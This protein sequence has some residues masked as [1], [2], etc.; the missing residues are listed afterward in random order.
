[1]EHHHENKSFKQ[2]FLS[3]LWGVLDL[4]KPCFEDI[5][6][7]IYEKDTGQRADPAKQR[8]RKRDGWLPI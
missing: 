8:R 3:E 4:Y 7:Y 1:M 5:M 2:L 6:A